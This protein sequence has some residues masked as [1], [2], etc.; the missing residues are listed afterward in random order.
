MTDTIFLKSI[1]K[2][3]KIRNPHIIDLDDGPYRFI[4]NIELHINKKI[5]ETEIVNLGYL[6]GIFIDIESMVEAGVED[7]VDFLDEYSQDT[8]NIAT[9]FLDDNAPL[10]KTFW[11][12]DNFNIL[13]IEKLF[14]GNDFRHTGLGSKIIE[15]IQD[16]M[17]EFHRIHLDTVFLEPSPLHEK[18]IKFS[19]KEKLYL[20]KKLFRF[21]R[22]LDFEKIKGWPAYMYKIIDK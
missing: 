4:S 6:T 16:I 7:L 14:I 8:L 12:L 3:K 13:Y 18:D 20:K 10:F 2:V 21:Y 1:C 11:C 19:E 15:N 17:L 22:K 5:S 9:I